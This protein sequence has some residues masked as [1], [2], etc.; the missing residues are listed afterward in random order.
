MALPETK[1]GNNTWYAFL[2]IENVPFMTEE[3]LHK[4]LLT[5]VMEKSSRTY[6]ITKRNKR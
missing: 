1:A 2:Y 6:T 4:N 3:G 5:L